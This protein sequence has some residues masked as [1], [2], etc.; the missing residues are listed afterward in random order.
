MVEAVV[1]AWRDPGEAG[2]VR[3]VEDPDGNV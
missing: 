1:G 2:V 3:D